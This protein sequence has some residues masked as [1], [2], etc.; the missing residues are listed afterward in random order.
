MYIGINRQQI[1]ISNENICICLLGNRREEE[2]G[3]T[4]QITAI[5][6]TRGNRTITH[7]AKA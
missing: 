2:T 4:A 5:A 1:M 6:R 7:G 3:R